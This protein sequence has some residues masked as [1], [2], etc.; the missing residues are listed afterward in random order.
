MALF[1]R[2]QSLIRLL[3]V[4]LGT[5]AAAGMGLSS[6]ADEKPAASANPASITAT[7]WDQAVPTGRLIVKYHSAEQPWQTPRGSKKSTRQSLRD[8][9]HMG[10][11]RQFSTLKELLVANK[12]ETDNGDLSQLGLL[13][14]LSA[15]FELRAQANELSAQ[16]EIDYASVEY[17]RYPLLEPLDPLYQGS[18]T[19]SDQSYLYDGDYSLHAPGAWDFTTGSSNSVIAIVDTGILPDHPEIR[20]RSVAGLGYDFVSADNPNDYTSANDGDGRDPSPVD[21]GDACNGGASS[22]HGTAVSSAAAANSNNNEGIAGIDWN[23]RLLHARALGICG[24]TDADI[25]DAIR[26]SAGLPVVGLPDNPNP[27]NVVNLSLG[28]T[29]E[30]T[31]AWQDVI[32]E[33]AD[34]NIVFVMAAGNEAR[35]ALRTSPANCANVITV[36]S[37]T[38]DGDVDEG[39]SNYGLKVTTATGGRDI[40]VASN[41]GFDAM[42]PEGNFYRTEIGTSFSAAL[43]SGAISLMHSLNPDLGP[44]EVR[45]ILQE[46]S[47]PYASD[48][49]CDLIYCGAG[50][51]NLSRALASVRDGNYNADRDATKE[52]IA[53]RSTEIQLQQKTTATLFGFR[54]I[55][56]FSVVVPERGL[57]QAR[58]SGTED[59]YGYLLNSDLSVIALDDDSGES[60][61]FR[62]ASLVDAGTYYIGVERE[63]HRQTDGELTFSLTTSVSGDAPTP[64][65]F[66]PISDATANDIVSSNTITIAGLEGES[67]LT[68]SDG[69]YVVNNGELGNTP[70]TVQNG[71]RLQIIAQSPGSPLGTS[72]TTVTVGA[73][74]TSFSLTTT[75]GSSRNAVPTDV[76]STAGCSVSGRAAFDPLLLLMLIL[77]SLATATRR[78]E[79]NQA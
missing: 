9:H 29:T 50:I 44:N 23:A 55:R 68:V 54:D 46:N 21:P 66:T 76:S 41:R 30:C 15:N 35:N 32:D 74:T 12:F 28:G 72:I 60:F 17:R 57:L 16:S 77:S 56:Y 64:F 13:Q 19:P 31:R 11:K 43:V 61:N 69:F 59:L 2:K 22:W 37:S 5:G 26:W 42:D 67:I 52:L 53:N 48:T 4:A 45:A 70:V 75:D 65:T 18:Q 33:L 39:F 49:N 40:V 34:L 3:L 63:R 10:L 38:P 79:R 24:G 8:N 14:Q 1:H 25:I 73:F 71:D 20:N 47:T 6:T 36:G 78:R 7:H 27:A 58:S 51:L 62:I